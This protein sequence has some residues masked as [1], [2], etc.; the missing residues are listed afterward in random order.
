MAFASTPSCPDVSSLH[1]AVLTPVI[2]TPFALKHG[3]LLA[4]MEQKAPMKRLGE[5]EDITNGVLYLAS[6]A[7]KFCTGSSLKI[8]GGITNFV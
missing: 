6:D 3:D 7:S 5:P 4:A 2:K 8:D 1:D